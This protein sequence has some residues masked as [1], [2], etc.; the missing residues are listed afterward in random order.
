MGLAKGHTHTEEEEE[1]EGEGDTDKLR[2]WAWSM[3]GPEKFC[4][5]K[6]EADTTV[7]PDSSFAP[8][9]SSVCNFDWPRPLPPLYT[10]LPRSSRERT[11]EEWE[12]ESGRVIQRD[13][14][15]V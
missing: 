15:K 7:S 9:A 3:V 11:R 4:M 12:R 10:C 5:H 8:L 14:R 13:S 2:I 1:E 6:S